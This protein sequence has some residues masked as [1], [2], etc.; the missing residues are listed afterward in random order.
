[1]KFYILATRLSLDGYPEH[2]IVGYDNK[3]TDDFDEVLLFNSKEEAQ[4]WIESDAAKE[5]Y[6]CSFE[7]VKFS[8][9]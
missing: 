3:P 6:G 9:V 7:P 1:M 5:W 8:E 4:T 2:L